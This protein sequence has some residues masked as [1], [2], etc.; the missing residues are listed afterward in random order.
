MIT[1]ISMS[2]KKRKVV[3]NHVVYKTDVY[4]HGV[5]MTTLFL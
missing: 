4:L 3:M 1:T 5:V 2:F